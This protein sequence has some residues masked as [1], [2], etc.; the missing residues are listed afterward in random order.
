M[1]HA[2]IDSLRTTRFV[3]NGLS[4]LGSAVLFTVVVNKPVTT[5]KHNTTRRGTQHSKRIFAI[6]QGVPDKTAQSCLAAAFGCVDD[7][8]LF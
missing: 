5:C 6:D 4:A 3:L 8:D 1:F 2:K 7:I